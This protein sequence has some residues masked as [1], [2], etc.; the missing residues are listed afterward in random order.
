MKKSGIIIAAIAIAL[1]LSGCDFLDVV[2]NDAPTLDHAFSNREVAYKFLSTCYSSLPDPCNPYY[3]PAWLDSGDEF[4]FNGDIT[5]RTNLYVP[6]QVLRGYQNTNDP[7]QNYWDGRQGGNSLYVGIRDCNIFL[8]NIDK[9]ADLT[10]EEKN[11]WIA[12][13]KFL[14]AYFHLFLVQMYGPI[15]IVKDNLPISADPK[16]TMLYREPVDDCIDYIVQLLDE[17]IADLPEML[18]DVNLE[19][20]RITKPIALA[21][22]AKALTLAASPLFNG[23]SD[24]AGW[25][26]NRG[27]QLISPTYDGSKWQKAADALKAAIE[28]AEETG[29]RLYEFNKYT[30]VQCYNMNDE[31]VQIMTIRKSVT[32]DI[33][34]NPG[35]IWATEE[36]W[37][38][39]KG[40]S[41]DIYR[42]M[43]DFPRMLVPRTWPQDDNISVSYF[44]ASWW[45]SQLFYSKN[46]VPIEEDVEFD[47]AN[48]N[49]M[50]INT[51]EDGHASY[52][53][54]GKPFPVLDYNREPR[55]Y[56]NLGFKYGFY[57]SSTNTTDAG[58]TFAPA[59]YSPQSAQ[60]LYYCKKLVPYEAS[61]T[62]GSANYTWTPYD[63][64]LPL[65]RL[66]D[67]YLM[68][69][70]ALNE[71][72]DAPDQEVYDYIDRVRKVAGLEGVVESWRS[73]SR[74]PDKPSTKDGMRE[75]IHKER[76]IEL[77]FE[78]QRFWDVRR[79]KEF[80]KYW[81]LPPTRWAD[82]TDSDEELFPVQY[83]PS[84][85]VS[86]RDG[87][88]P[89]RSY[90]LR[91]NTNLVQTFGW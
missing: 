21:V 59:I 24:Y 62:R 86:F 35:V 39:G 7:Y 69:S 74:T 23:N 12:E 31:L 4:D 43:S 67:I 38:N 29:H 27:R 81:S 55:F 28:I 18:I 8:E 88:W 87:L 34:K 46:G 32:E 78:G 73:F 90:T 49:K 76:L 80:E 41:A 50:K 71:V 17:A 56:A 70:E 20:G 2:P 89:M 42:V 22:K 19:Q 60:S 40:G 25:T 6:G 79:W 33:D 45:M 13:V 14:K 11:R 68:Y 36:R 15:V 1:N 83:Y 91:V 9:P 48:R 52:M 77:A 26:D 72:K 44:P 66:A 82:S 57:E 84:R 30:A 75:I 85:D 5:A 51:E 58:A 10:E 47:Y 37:D 64:R 53:S 61:T 16:E 54:I 3:Y 65:I 63:Y